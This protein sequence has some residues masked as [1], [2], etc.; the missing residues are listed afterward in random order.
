MSER[1]VRF[2]IAMEASLLREFDDVVEARGGT[3]SEAFR[4]L[5]RGAV[6]RSKIRRG[7]EAVATLTLVYDHHVRDLTERLTQLQHDLGSRVRSTL[8][9]H[10][11]H[12]SCLEVIVMQG[13]ADQLQ[14]I[15]DRI[16]A[17]KGVKHGGIELYAG[18]DE[19][20]HH[21]SHGP[22]AATEH[23]H[24]APAASVSAGNTHRK[25]KKAPAE[26]P[27]RK[28]KAKTS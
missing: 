27:G 15:A 16:V 17:L 6:I 13:R 8:H 2:G 19:S 21:H 11:D 14:A 12:E 18:L 24:A 28:R 10:L 23:Q 20:Q 1:L 26:T 4:D 5:A 9:I 3:R 7:A 25:P 22:E